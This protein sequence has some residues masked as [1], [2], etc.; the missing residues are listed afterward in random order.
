MAS[1]SSAGGGGRF[2]R[3]ADSKIVFE[4][5]ANVKVVSSFEQMG[6]KEDLLR[7]VYA[8]GMH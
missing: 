4:T 8:Y 7:G 1:S 3:N 5:S 2:D 6:L